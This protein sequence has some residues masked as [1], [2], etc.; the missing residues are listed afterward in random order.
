M[1]GKASDVHRRLQEVFDSSHQDERELALESARCVIFSDHH[2]GQ[3]DG[4][5]DFRRCER[6]YHAA[7]GY[8]LHAG[9]T[10]LALGDV[11]ELW[12]CRPKKVIK[13]YEYT[14]GLEAEFQKDGRYERFSGNHDDE[15]ES[16]KSVKKYLGKVFPGI[17]VKEG[18]RFRVTSG[19][20]DLGTLFLAHGHQGTTF[21]DRRRKIARFFVRNVWRPIQRFLNIPSTTPAKDFELREKHD[22][23]MYSWAR[24]QEKVVLIAG[25]THRPVFMS[26]SHHARLEAKLAGATGKEA[27]EARAM[28]EWTKAQGEHMPGATQ[29]L[30]GAVKP[31]YFN[32]G[33]CSFGDGDITCLEIIDGE[34]RLVRWPDDEGRPRPKILDSADLK[35][36]VFSAL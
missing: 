21:S 25:H 19:G 15:W 29:R 7:L 1:S 9:Y 34:I 4:A 31:C 26:A 3:R 30:E 13:A 28:L 16:S 23:T 6:A 2:K 18:A 33:C 12:E 8:Y 5:D 11:E 32:S 22:V 27:A 10:L 20:T 17:E 24:N 14:L 36:E 35:T